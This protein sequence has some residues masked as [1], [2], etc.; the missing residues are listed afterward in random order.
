MGFLKHGSDA[1]LAASKR[2]AGRRLIGRAI[3]VCLAGALLALGGCGFF[4]GDT[5]GGVRETQFEDSFIAAK[6][7]GRPIYNEDVRAFAVTTGRIEDGQELAA[8]SPEYQLALHDLITERLFALEAESRGLDRDPEV[9]RQLDAARERILASAIFRDIDEKATDQQTIERLYRENARALGEIQEVHIRHIQ[10]DTREAALA[11]RRRLDEGEQFERLAFELSRDRETGPE[12]GELGWRAVDDLED[13]IRQAA[14]SAASGEVAGPVQSTV[15][16]H[17][18][19]IVD[20][21]Q[22]GAP[23]L[24]QLR[25]QIVEWQRWQ[26]TN[27][28]R[29]RL[30]GTARIEIAAER[31]VGVE[32]AG[33]AQEPPDRPQA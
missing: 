17:L 18:L 33:D 4:G 19:Q 7:N 14:E 11:A 1:L 10:F 32:G 6:V 12:G 30:E 25:E 22:R 27:R 28:L 2:G 23:S 21:R 15:G 5:E 16:W 24:A 8:D 26:E 29:E 20:R 31:T 9:R 13:G 3:G